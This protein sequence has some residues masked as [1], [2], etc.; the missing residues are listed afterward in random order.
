MNYEFLVAIKIIFKT[1]V[2]ATK[3][4]GIDE[5]R[6]SR[7]IHGHRAPTAEERRRFAAA[8]G[9]DLF[10]PDGNPVRAENSAG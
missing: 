5:P 6:L 9:I 4:L 8:L 1:Q 7:L 10:A 2:Q 3:K